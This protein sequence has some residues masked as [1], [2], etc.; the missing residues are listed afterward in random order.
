MVDNESAASEM[1]S[2][3][4]QL[5]Q[6]PTTGQTTL[7]ITLEKLT[8]HN[9]PSWAVAA[10]LYIAGCDELGFFTGDQLMPDPLH[11]LFLA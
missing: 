9:Y 11:S 7:Q 6:L 8:E 3:S 2:P 4:I 5:V 10:E 1:S